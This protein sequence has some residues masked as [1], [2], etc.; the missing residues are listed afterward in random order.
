MKD[1]I[2][3]YDPDLLYFDCSIP[4]RGEDQGQTGMEVISHLYNHSM[5]A[6]GGKQEAVMCIKERPWQ[7]VYAPG[8]ATLDFERGKANSILDDPWQTDDSIGSWG[9]NES[10]P[11]TTSGAVVDKLI[12]IVSKNGCLLLN[13]P[14]LADGTLDDKATKILEEIG[15]WMDVNGEAIYGTRPWYLYGEGKTVLPHKV[16]ESPFKKTD[17]RYTT[18]D[19]ALYAFVLDWP[20]SKKPVVFPQLTETNRRIGKVANVVLLGH[21]GEVDWKNDGDG[22]QVLFPQKKPTDFA[23]VLK[24]TFE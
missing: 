12:D 11:Y 17:F 14:I 20:G 15:E 22:L 7:G 24:I 8:V 21:D 4:F 16:I 9:Y 5:Q 6:H 19:G 13:I 1:L 2:D 3:N 10:V 18:K 23:H